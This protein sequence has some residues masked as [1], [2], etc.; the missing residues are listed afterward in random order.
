MT[1][2]SWVGSVEATVMPDHGDIFIAEQRWRPNQYEMA[3][4]LGEGD[5]DRAVVLTRLFTPLFHNVRTRIEG[6][7]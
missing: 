4:I 3:A 5:A 6:Q 7:A 1:H 2:V